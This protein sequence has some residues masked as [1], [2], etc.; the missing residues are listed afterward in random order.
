M[1]GKKS[2]R[3]Q[4]KKNRARK[5]WPFLIALGGIALIGLALWST[6]RGD[7]TPV[8][9]IEVQG[10]PSLKVDQEKVDLG[11]IRL[12]ETVSASFTLTNVGDK[13]LRLTDQPY[14][15]VAAGC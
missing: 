10:A 8:A 11:D 12:G 4:R 9:A 1:N 2:K 5:I 3:S 7:A 13:P 6:R 14:I 15:E